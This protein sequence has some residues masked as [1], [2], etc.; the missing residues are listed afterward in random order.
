[1]CLSRW[2]ADNTAQISDPHLLLLNL[3]STL[4]LLNDLLDQL[5]LI[6]VVNVHSAEEVFFLVGFPEHVQLLLR[7]DI[8]L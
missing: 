3:L 2:C 6:Y 7:V 1:M 5:L 8:L 4:S